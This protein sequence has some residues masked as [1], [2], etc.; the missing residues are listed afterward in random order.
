MAS[1][2]DNLAKLV[3]DCEFAAVNVLVTR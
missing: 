1:F 3:P 2:Y